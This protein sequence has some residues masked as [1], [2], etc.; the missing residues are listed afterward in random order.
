MDYQESYDYSAEKSYMK[1]TLRELSKSTSVVDYVLFE[2]ERYAQAESEWG[3]GHTE[4]D[5]YELKYYC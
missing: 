3:A 1:Y 2:M 4:A 5:L